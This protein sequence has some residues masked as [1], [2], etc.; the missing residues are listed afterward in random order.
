MSEYDDIRFAFN[1]EAVRRIR[2]LLST[3]R[4]RAACPICGATLTMAGPLETPEDKASIF[5]VRCA[6][7]HR[8]ALINEIPWSFSAPG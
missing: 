5:E 6:G 8:S 3:P 4:D 2:S 7:C 1:R